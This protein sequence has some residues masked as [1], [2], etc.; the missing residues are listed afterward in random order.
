[1]KSGNTIIHVEFKASGA[2]FYFGGISAIFEV[3]TVKDIGVGPQRLY[4]FDVEPE[5]PYQNKICIIRKGKIRR[6]AGNRK[7]PKT[8]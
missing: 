3:F 8:D 7:N 6:K 4:D 5:K 2:H 1:M